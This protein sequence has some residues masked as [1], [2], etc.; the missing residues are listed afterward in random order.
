MAP[1]HNTMNNKTK[2][3][4]I[5]ETIKGCPA[6]DRYDRQGIENVEISETSRVRQLSGHADMLLTH[7]ISGMI[8]FLGIMY[9]IFQ[10]TFTAGEPLTALLEHVFG[11]MSVTL[12]N[13][14][15]RGRA[16]WLESLIIDGVLGG[17]GGV[18]VF[19]PNVLLL[20]LGI[21]LLEE[22]GYMAR[23]SLLTEV[24][25][26]KGGLHGKSFVPMVIGF[27]CS[28]PAILATRSIE[29]PRRRLITILVLPLISCSARYSIYA[30]IIPAFFSQIWRGPVLM[31]IYLVGVV[32]AIVAAKVLS[33]TLIKTQPSASSV[34]LPQYRWPNLHTM[35]QLV[36]QRGW[37]C[38]R[39]AGTI[40]LLASVILWG[41][42]R[43]P[44]VN[45]S[46]VEGKVKEA[47]LSNSIV[48]KAGHVL[49]HVLKPLGFDWKISTALVCAAAGKEIF[50]S[51]MAILH[52]SGRQEAGT[53]TLRHHL[54]STYSPLIGF[55]VM[56]FALISMPCVGTIAITKNETGSW[57][58][59]ALQ[60]AGLTIL[61]YLVTM[62]VFQAGR[63]FIA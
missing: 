13:L 34:T 45:G 46:S 31:L 43:Y 24:V 20:F 18:L 39:K 16:L 40:T 25:M 17:V 56:L 37:L 57:K 41:A 1:E 62:I 60:L 4:V 27:D 47:Q 14:W 48:G 10:L 36:W 38:V 61:A 42:T 58:W 53:E 55:C 12:A 52:A 35:W 21:A 15:P 44:Q 49:E 51:Q 3:A 11:W 29:D 63:L 6:C 54:R 32:M 8:I 5:A 50:V 26:L 33:K 7:P 19:L 2:A 23:V 22:T 59:A 28:V 30:M 9:G